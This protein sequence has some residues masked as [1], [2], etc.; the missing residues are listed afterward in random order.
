MPN[1]LPVLNLVGLGSGN[2]EKKVKKALLRGK[3][4]CRAGLSNSRNALQPVE[5]RVKTVPTSA[6]G[7]LRKDMSRTQSLGTQTARFHEDPSQRGLRD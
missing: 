5:V 2:K 6:L 3:T 4:S 7:K 1:S